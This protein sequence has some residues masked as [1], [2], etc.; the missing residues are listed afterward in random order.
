MRD[1]T[2]DSKLHTGLNGRMPEIELRECSPQDGYDILEMLHEIGPG[3]NGFQNS[4][5]NT[6]PEDFKDL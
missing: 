1:G 5:Y 6:K 4:A 3:E 2:F